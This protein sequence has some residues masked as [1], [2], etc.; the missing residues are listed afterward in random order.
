MCE[1]IVGM[2]AAE[3]AQDGQFSGHDVIAGRPF[4]SWLTAG[5]KSRML[6][7][8]DYDQQWPPSVCVAG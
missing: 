6:R 7:L 8:A 4:R 3:S 2:Q 1:M 5:T